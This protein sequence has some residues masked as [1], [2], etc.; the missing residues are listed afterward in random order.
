MKN[1]NFR[2]PISTQ[3]S[4][5][6]VASNIL[7]SMVEDHGI[8][9]CL[10]PIGQIEADNKYHA[11]LQQSVNN[12]EKFDF[13]A[14]AL[15]V[16]HEH[17]S[18]LRLGKGKN[19]LLSFFELNK[20]NEKRKNSIQS[21][22]VFLVASEWAKQIVQYDIPNIPVEVIPIGV[23]TDIFRPFSLNMEKPYR[24]LNVGKIEIRKGHDILHE[25]FN[26]AF[27]KE[28]NVELYIAWDNPFMSK[29]E[30]NKW[31]KLYKETELGD[32]I[33]FINR[34]DSLRTEYA[35]ADC[36]IFPTRA[37]AICLPVLEAFASNKPVIITN[38]SGHTQFCNKDNSFLVEVDK[39]ETANDG[40]WFNGEGEWAHLG[41]NQFAQFIEYMRN[42]YKN[43]IK[44]N[45]AGLKTAQELTWK[46]TARKINEILFS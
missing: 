11:L 24:F 2:S 27:T 28:D 6:I 39:L 21:H 44:E 19:A 12:Q 37:E 31:I 16:W 42:C 46:N 20:L 40:V 38:Y 13:N 10:F 35:A 7:Y 17:D 14:P 3:I 36:C 32:K 29:E 41:D 43:N 25:I 45:P 15:T 34:Q 9:P 1:L 18:H 26:A 4:Y 8:N 22:D 23:N 30:K 33:Y 5:G